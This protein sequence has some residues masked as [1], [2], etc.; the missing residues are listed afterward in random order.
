MSDHVVATGECVWNTNGVDRLSAIGAK[1]VDTWAETA[2][3]VFAILVGNRCSNHLTFGVRY[4]YFH[5]LQREAALGGHDTGQ[6][7]A[8]S[9][10]NERKKDRETRYSDK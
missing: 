6:V 5:I 3:L 4:R 10:T 8:R 7:R 1:G 9:R 2:Y